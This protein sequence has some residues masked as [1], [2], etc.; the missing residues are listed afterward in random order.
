M[1]TRI[2]THHSSGS[3]QVSLYFTKLLVSSE[4]PD[5]L[6]KPSSYTPSRLFL[7]LGVIALFA[8]VF[9]LVYAPPIYAT[10]GLTLFLSGYNHVNGSSIAIHTVAAVIA[11]LLG[12]TAVFTR[13][14]GARHR[15]SGT[16]AVISLIFVFVTAFALLIL[17]SVIPMPANDPSRQDTLIFLTVTFLGGSYTTLQGYRW[18]ACKRPRIPTDVLMMGVALF[19]SVF[20]FAY[21]PY[22][23]FYRPYSSSNVGLPMT[24]VTAAGL[25]LAV[26]FVLLYFFVDDLK[27]YLGGKA[28]HDE[29]ILKHT[30]RIMFMVGTALTTVVIVHFSP[31]FFRSGWPVW[32]LYVAPQVLIG[33]VTF[34]RAGQIKAASAAH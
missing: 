11:C 7:V 26:G 9:K 27:T 17:A 15:W 33:A 25:F 6:D 18:V 28:T 29:R 16:A 3:S 34:R 21:L 20:C 24:P 22:E 32:P 31:F 14:G 2:A 23:V 5:S 12:L 4:I 19:T 13:K 30:Y 8:L 10:T 1:L